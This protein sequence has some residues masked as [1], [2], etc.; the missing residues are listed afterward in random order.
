M[1]IIIIRAYIYIYIYIYIY[2]YGE[3]ILYA[4][5]NNFMV[6]ILV[7]FIKN[8]TELVTRKYEN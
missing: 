2:T 6:Q 5:T 4:V 7:I 3:P 8:I 1:I